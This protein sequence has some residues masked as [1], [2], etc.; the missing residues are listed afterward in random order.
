MVSRQE[1]LIE[2]SLKNPLTKAF[3][4]LYLSILGITPM[5]LPTTTTRHHTKHTVQGKNLRLIV[6]WFL[7]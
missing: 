5:F 3:F 1:D 6:F 7:T 2:N 4:C